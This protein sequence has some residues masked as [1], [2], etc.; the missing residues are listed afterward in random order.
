LKNGSQ[1]WADDV[2]LVAPAFVV[3]AIA[4]GIV[5]LMLFAMQQGHVAWPDAYAWRVTR[6]SLLQAT[7]ST[8]LSVVPSILVARALA[9][10]DFPGRHLL[11]ALFAVPLSLPAIVAIFGLTALYGASGLLGGMFNLYGLGGIVLAHVF[12]NLPLATRL[13]LEALNAAPPES[14]RLAAQLNFTP[15]DVFRL[16]DWPALKPALPRV[17]AL[18]FLVCASSFVI[19]LAL[20]G[21]QATTLEVAIYQSLRMDF[22]VP[23][24][25]TLS[26]L[27]IVLSG[28]L[29]WLAAKA[30]NLPP[31]DTATRLS[32][33]RLDGKAKATQL[34]DAAILLLAIALVLPVLAAILIQGV[35]E[36]EP[37]LLLG[38]A[39][40]TSLCIAGLSCVIA[41]PLAWNMSL[42]QARWP[43]WRGLLSTLGLAAFIVPPAVIATGWF[44]AVRSVD[45]GVVLAVTLIAVMNALMALPF[46]LTVLAPALHRH[47][48][49]YDRLCAQLGISGFNRL[50]VIDVT[51]LRGPLASAALM[52][53]VLSMGDLAAVTLLGAQGLVTLPSLVLQQMGHYQSEAAGG[54]ALMLGIICLLLAL[55]AQKVAAWT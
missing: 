47:T 23:R 2:K 37:S 39:F 13:L 44:L 55:A 5:P 42:A 22:D 24:A 54:T 17:A 12:F 52:A 35:G 51:A 46:T 7:L 50:W 16:V 48:Q 19:V 25:L 30:M 45:G 28:A 8:L 53:F 9:R 41:V 38:K 4:L 15:R 10:Q 32:G 20:G 36:I 33:V 26:M 3:A 27:Q 6:F 49:S 18:V 21:A 1:V 31:H 11:L 40:A 43:R 34:I 29:V 14:H